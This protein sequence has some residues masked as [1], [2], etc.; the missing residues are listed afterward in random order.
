MVDEKKDQPVYMISIAAKLTGMHPQTLRIYERKKLLRP[1]RTAKSTRLYS[2]HDIERV[3]YIQQLTQEEGVNLAGVKI[4]MALNRQLEDLN[5]TAD[6][7]E[8]R[9][10]ERRRQLEDEIH[11]VHRSYR[12]ELVWMPRAEIVK[13]KGK[14]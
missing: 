2:E 8:R 11:Q 7:L 12:R 3:K 14:G 6:E 1:G 10:D 5:R 4:I 9:A 13:V